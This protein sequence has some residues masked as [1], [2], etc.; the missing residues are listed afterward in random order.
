[1]KKISCTLLII[2]TVFGSFWFYLDQNH[3][4]PILMYHSLDEKRIGEYAAVSPKRFTQQMEF[5]K[6]N[7][8]RVISLRNYCQSLKTGVS[9]PRKSLVITFDDGHKDNLK[10]S[11]ILGELKFP[12]TLF[13]ITNKIGAKGY[14]TEE[15]VDFLLETTSLEIG[16]HTLNEAYLPE[17][18]ADKLKLEISESRKKLKRMFSQN[19]ETFSYT[20]GGF[21]KETIEEVKQSGYLCACTTNRGFS[22]QLNLFA[23]RRIKVTER[24]SGIRLWAKLSGFYNVLRKPKKPY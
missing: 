7:G 20:I 18:P 11:K 22:R 2:L 23:L 12:F 16:S 17:T 24:D 1:M 8:Y 13:L 21:T 14:L 5:I 10:A 3:E 19:I 6:N 4:V 9:V 15:E